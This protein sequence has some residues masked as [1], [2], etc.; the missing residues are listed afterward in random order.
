MKKNIVFKLAT[1]LILSLI[2]SIL[3]A[4]LV[5]IC[6]SPVISPM[7]SVLSLVTG[8]NI[9]NNIRINSIYVP[10]N[11][12][13]PEFIYDDITGALVEVKENLESDIT[14]TSDIQ[15]P[16]Y[17]DMYGELSIDSVGICLDLYMGDN[18]S[19]LKLG[20][21]QYYASTIP[22]MAGRTII[23]GHNTSPYFGPL[24]TLV[25]NDALI[26][27]IIKISTS[28]GNFY[29]SIY[30]YDIKHYTDTSAF[31]SDENSDEDTLVMYTCYPFTLGYKSDRLYIYAEKIAGRNV[32]LG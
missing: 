15:F 9:Q 6:I 16:K 8:S 10:N 26:G 30:D 31:S 5:Y 32:I 4:L 20:V 19:L 12:A 28:Y 24:D 21:G 1:N 13:E 3:A 14:Y 25:E 7:K 23:A 11:E 18:L 17:G 27:E 2:Y 29:Y 22:G